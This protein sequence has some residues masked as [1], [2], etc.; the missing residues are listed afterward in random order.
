MV[1]YAAARKI[2]TTWGIGSADIALPKTAT[3]TRF[4]GDRKR[5]DDSSEN[6]F[7]IPEIDPEDEGKRQNEANNERQRDGQTERIF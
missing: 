7:P 4:V 3:S 1:D 6:A 2:R 5:N